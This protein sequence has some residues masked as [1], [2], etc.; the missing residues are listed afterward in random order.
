VTTEDNC[1]ECAVDYAL[2]P[3]LP[4][5]EADCPTGFTEESGECTEPVNASD[6][7]TCFVWSEKAVE[8]T[9]QRT[10]NAGSIVLDAADETTHPI[11]AYQ[12]GIWFDGD[13]YVYLT[14]VILNT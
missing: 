12:R 11:P 1:S 6:L 7:D 10:D 13:D 3:G 5:C 8:I 14:D 2:R 4:L 9:S